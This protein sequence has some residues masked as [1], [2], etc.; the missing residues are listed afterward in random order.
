MPP[1]LSHGQLILQTYRPGSDIPAAQAGARF[2]NPLVGRAGVQGA[3]ADDVPFG[4]AGH[5]G[6]NPAG[7]VFLDQALRDKKRFDRIA[8]T[9]AGPPP[10]NAAGNP[11]LSFYLAPAANVPYAACLY[12]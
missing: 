9:G 6:N 10:D 1:H 4:G 2:I 3:M 11:A 8:V 7:G 5:A 12:L